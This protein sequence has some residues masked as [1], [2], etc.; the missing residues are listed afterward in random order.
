MNTK[1]KILFLVTQS[2]FG[3]AQRFIYR[4]ITNLD[5]FKYEII[6]AAGPEG[7]DANGLLFNLKKEDFRTI[8]LKFL[9]RGVNPLF[10]FGLGL[11][12]IYRL[13]KREKPDILFL[14][15]SKAGAMG[16]LIGRLLKTPKIIYRIG[17][18]TFNDPWPSWK[19]KLYIFLEKKTAKFKDII[20]N[21]A[22][23]DRQQAIKLGIKPKEKIIT[24]Y[25]GVDV[26][27]LDFLAKDEAKIF[28]GVPFGIVIGTIANFYPPKGLDYLIKAADLIK[29]NNIKF[30]IIG[31]GEETRKLENL[32]K[33]YNLGDKFFLLGA[34]PEAYKYLKAF[35]VFVL[36]SVKEG[37]PWTILEA[38]A[39]EIPIIAT[40]VGAVPEI[41]QTDKNGLLIEPASPQVIA[42]S[43]M[44]LLRDERFRNN[45]AAEGR[46]TVKEK[47]NLKKMV[48]Q[49]ENL[50]SI[51]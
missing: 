51:N 10:D 27:K 25:N 9:R 5:L 37:F 18:W 16:S 46:K 44:K 26:E 7:N 11:V 19:K 40:E 15:S 41:I 36:S 43:I 12:E 2:E 17:G 45:I 23:S 33:E 3:G 14:C 1:K 49:Y 29:D 21:N 32:V 34:I 4:L 6:T 47:F 39:A 35:D 38:M 24:I 50:F 48:A 42:D 28:L 22:E 31:E 20:V 30:V 13:I 8:A